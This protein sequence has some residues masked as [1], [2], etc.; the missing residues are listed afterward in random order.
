[1]QKKYKGSNILLKTLQANNVQSFFGYPG[2]V[3]LGLYDEIYKQQ[4]IRHILV[5][6]EQGAAHAADGYA[7]V[8]SKP[9]V[10]LATSGPGATNL[11]T[12]ICSAQMDSI[13]IIALTGQVP[14]TML[15]KDAFQ[16]AD[17]FNLSL[18][19][20]KHSYLVNQTHKVSESIQKA[21]KIATSNRP[22]PVLVD[23]PKDI[24]NSEID[25]DEQIPEIELP[26]LA[27]V[28][29]ISDKDAL[30]AAEMI[31]DAKQ[32]VLYI[33]GGVIHSDAGELV[34][35]LAESCNIPI[36]WTLMGKGA[37]ADDHQLN[38]GMLGMHG[39]PSANYSIYESDLLIAI[40][41]RFDD[42]ATGK[43]EAFAPKA[44]VIHIDIDP[45]EIGK[46]R[47]IIPG[48][49]LSISADAK[50]ALE[51]ILPMLPA[52]SSRNT[53]QWIQKIRQWQKDYPLDQEC[54]EDQLSPCH[55]FK[56]LNEVAED[57]IYTTDVGQHQM[58][59]AQYLN[60]RNPRRWITSGGLG[61]MG[62]GL[63]AA[64]GAKVAA[65][66][67][68]LDKPVICI[69]GDGSF[70]MCQQELGTMIAHNIPVIV[71]ILNNNNLGM[72]RQWQQLF[73]DN[74]YSYSH[75]NDGSPDYV[76]LANSYGIRGQKIDTPHNLHKIIESAIECQEPVVLDMTLHPEANVFPI[77]SPGGANHRAEGIGL[78]TVPAN[79]DYA[80]YQA[81]VER[82]P[83][84]Q[85]DKV[86]S[87][88]KEPANIDYADYQE[89]EA[90]KLS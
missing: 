38:L 13:P 84:R 70:Q 8:A 25:W 29:K 3:L 53:D 36:V 64:I 21:F 81:K 43:L 6:H 32:A 65:Q 85:L 10:C 63:P 19:I 47:R 11:L 54:F 28:N 34:K 23:L 20:T 60:C 73:F 87:P 56:A 1:M 4:N 2:G 44:K 12:G 79:I 76:K 33:G 50:Q 5:R 74:H 15:G 17:L 24:L 41:V 45:A 27:S 31:L 40:G 62:F 77:V 39:T 58:W 83:V 55:I 16:E 51:V 66:D 26:G 30:A 14:S 86:V 68:G 71:I 88:K 80:D 67:I 22:G 9:G 42:R 75:L 57:A 59:A 52:N 72:V 35:K 89:R 37:V 46:N 69:T 82:S 48:V 7:R 78:A 90:E 18:P 49:D 61:T